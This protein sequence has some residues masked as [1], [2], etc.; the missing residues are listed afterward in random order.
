MSFWS[1][2]SVMLLVGPLA[3]L[4]VARGEALDQLAGDA[5]D[6]LGRA[7]AGHL[8]GFLERDLAVVDHGRDVGDGARLH[9]RE[10]LA[11]AA[12]RRGRCR[13]RRRRSR[14]PAPWRTPCRC[15]ARC[16]R[17][18]RSPS[19]AGGSGARRPC[20]GGSAA[21][22]V[23]AGRCAL[24]S[25]RPREWLPARSAAGR[26]A[27]RAPGPC[28]ADRRPALDARVRRGLTSAPAE[29]PR[30][31]RSS[32]TVTKSCGSSASSA[33]AMTPVAEHGAHVRANALRSSIESNRRE[34]GDE[35]RAIDGVGALRASSAGVAAAGRPPAGAAR[36]R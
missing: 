26:D 18:A 3:L 14:R 24:G 8:L 11:L 7:E 22:P 16:T 33:R 17:R 34:Y 20:Y 4:A 15:R 29:T 32:L 25:R 21:W 30:A 2:C 23:A 19:A 35:P 9:V 27:C 12:R 1:S 5:D 10:T 28:P 31:T 13:R 36:D 6:D